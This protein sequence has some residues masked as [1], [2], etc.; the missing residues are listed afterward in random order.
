MP[1]ISDQLPWSASISKPNRPSGIFD[2]L[3]WMTGAPIL[4]RGGAAGNPSG[5]PIM[6][7]TGSRPNLY[8]APSVLSSNPVRL[9]GA[10]SILA[11]VRLRGTK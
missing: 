1:W 6:L 5:P 4:I 8:N 9:Y 3:N 7:G 2:P 10:P 11:G